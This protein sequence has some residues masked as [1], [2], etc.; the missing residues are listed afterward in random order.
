MKVFKA[1][2]RVLLH[3]IAYPA[4]VALILYLNWDI[5]DGQFVNYG[6]FTLVGVL[7]AAVM[8]LV[9]YIFYPIITRKKSK[10]SKLC[11]TVCVILIPVLSLAGLW[12]GC[13][14]YLPDFISDATSGTISYEDLAENN[15]KTRAQVNADLINDFIAMN[16]QIGTLPFPIGMEEEEEVIQYYQTVGLD[17]EIEVLVEE[18]CPYKT[19]NELLAIQYQ[20]IDG[21]GYTA[22]TDP[23]IGFANGG[24]L[25][26][27]C[28]IHLILDKRT[29]NPKKVDLESPAVQYTENDDG[30]ITVDQVLFATYDEENG[31]YLADWQWTVL[32]M[33]GENTELALGDTLKG[34]KVLGEMTIFDLIQMVYGLNDDLIPNVLND[35]SMII[36]DEDIAGSEIYIQYDS[37]TGN[38]ALVPANTA[39]GVHGY[40]KMAW[41]DS[42][43]LIYALVTLFSVRNVFIAFAGWIAFIML[44]DAGLRGVCKDEKQ[45][46]KKYLA[47][48]DAA[49]KPQAPVEPEEEEERVAIPVTPAPLSGCKVSNS[50]S[51]IQRMNRER[52]ERQIAQDP[53]GNVYR[54]YNVRDFYR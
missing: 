50:L 38:L 23:W 35:V 43:G 37:E 44:L 24:R 13:D 5:I 49:V 14:R 1:I 9:F 47:Q 7:I 28:L 17:T 31:L 39:R 16:V 10:K 22:F 30:T 11:Q 12:A 19:I 20:S 34:V 54:G 21:N 4:M 45:R 40:M 3:L 18:E 33:T 15:W 6:I 48:L 29:V 2:L 27:P 51:D 26:I 53:Y 32:D 36:A 41:L 8:M 52:I 46:R 25:T 42:N